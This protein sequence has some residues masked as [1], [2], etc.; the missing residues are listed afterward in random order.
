MAWG[1][2]VG[3]A[4]ATSCASSSHVSRNWRHWLTPV[5]AQSAAVKTVIWL[6][7]AVASTLNCCQASWGE[8]APPQT[9]SPSV[10]LSPPLGSM[11]ARMFI[12]KALSEGAG[13]DSFVPRPRPKKV[14]R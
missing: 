1:V 6:P 10:A 8:P 9:T 14:K 5:T 3:A 12:C 4:W 11:P 2:A 7:V 13:E